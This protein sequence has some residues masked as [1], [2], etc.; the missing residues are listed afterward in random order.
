M[1][2][3]RGEATSTP[4]IMSYTKNGNGGNTST[5]CNF[6]F[7]EPMQFL[8]SCNRTPDSKINS[9]LRDGLN[10]RGP[11]FIFDKERRK[12]GDFLNALDGAGFAGSFVDVQD[13]AAD[14][15]I[16]GGDGKELMQAG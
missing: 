16:A 13:A 7:T 1:K 6:Y 5:P 8:L 4:N 2:F 3:L 15:R 14:E 9:K 12:A 10:G 11:L